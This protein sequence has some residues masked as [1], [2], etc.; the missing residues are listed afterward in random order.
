MRYAVV[1]ERS[2]SN[3]VLV[4]KLDFCWILEVANKLK[5]SFFFSVVI[6]KAIE[7]NSVGFK[8]ETREKVSKMQL[9]FYF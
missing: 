7:M 2:L 4:S 1:H 3:N 6:I 5:N 9:G 8:I